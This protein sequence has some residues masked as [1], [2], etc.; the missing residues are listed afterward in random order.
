M[1]ISEHVKEL[2]NYER[3]FKVD[4]IDGKL[5]P[6]FGRAADTIEFLSAKLAGMER[7]AEDCGGGWIYCNERFPRLTEYSHE[8]VLKRLEIAYMAEAVE[9]VIGYYDG[10]KWM[11]KGNRKIE[12]VI[13]WKPFLKL[14]EKRHES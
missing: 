3:H 14:P 12:N 11:D 7:T 1:S 6:I 13:A 2:R 5:S 8:N 10:Y 4:R 9:Y